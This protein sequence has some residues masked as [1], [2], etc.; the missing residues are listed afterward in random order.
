MRVNP[1]FSVAVEEKMSLS[2][3]EATKKLVYDAFRAAG[4]K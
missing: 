3:D 2:R 1:K 4:L